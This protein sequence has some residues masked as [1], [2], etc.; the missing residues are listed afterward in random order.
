[1]L[2]FHYQAKKLR[3][4]SQGENGIRIVMEEPEKQ[5]G[6]G[7]RQNESTGIASAAK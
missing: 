7:G 5:S 6:S 4:Y 2:Y 3:R 1:M